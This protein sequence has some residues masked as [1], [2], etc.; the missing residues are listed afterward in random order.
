[1]IVRKMIVLAPFVVA[2]QQRS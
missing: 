1:M 2:E